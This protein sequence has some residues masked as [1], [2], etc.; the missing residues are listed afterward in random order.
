MEQTQTAQQA[1]KGPTLE[2]GLDGM[3]KIEDRVSQWMILEEHWTQYNLSRREQLGH[4]KRLFQEIKTE[5]K[6]A[7]ETCPAYSEV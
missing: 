4:A 6:A 3:K 2:M 7:Y 5:I 1:Q